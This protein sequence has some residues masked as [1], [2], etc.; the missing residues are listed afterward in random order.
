MREKAHLDTQYVDDAKIRLECKYLLTI[1]ANNIIYFFFF[2]S[3]FSSQSMLFSSA[4]VLMM[5]DLEIENLFGDKTKRKLSFLIYTSKLES[6]LR[7]SAEHSSG[8]VTTHTSNKTKN[9][10]EKKEKFFTE[11]TAS[12]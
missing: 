5:I 10:A 4:Y 8:F 11:D 2:S 3:P 12:R 9:L 6:K 1:S 7:N